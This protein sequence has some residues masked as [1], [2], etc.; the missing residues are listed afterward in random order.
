VDKLKNIK[1]PKSSCWICARSPLADYFVICTADSERQARR[2]RA[3]ARGAQAGA[4]DAAVVYGGEP[5]PVGPCSTT[6]SSSSTS[7][8]NRRGHITGWRAVE[9]RAGGLKD[10]IEAKTGAA[11]WPRFCASERCVYSKIQG[12]RSARIH[13][14]LILEPQPISKA[15]VSA[16]RSRAPGCGPSPT[17]VGADV[18]GAPWPGWWR[19]GER[20]LNGIRPSSTS[21]RPAAGDVV[22]QPLVRTACRRA[23][24]SAVRRTPAHPEHLH[25][26]DLQ[27]APLKALDDLATTRAARV[28]FQQT[29]VVSKGLGIV[30][31]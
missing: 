27:P 26:D 25:G 15:A 5:V 4:Q 17:V 28:R 9:G 23:P 20:L 6:T 3:P 2:S 18:P 14:L 10:T 1:R 8:R 24:H 7:S 16:R 19:H 12:R 22:D 29:N 30:D 21:P 31:W 11:G 13:D